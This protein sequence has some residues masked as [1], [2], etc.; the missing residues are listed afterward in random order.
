[1]AVT[2]CIVLA[3]LAGAPAVAAPLDLPPAADEPTADLVGTS[4]VDYSRKT[5]MEL[6]FRTRYVSLPSS[7]LDIWYFNE[8]DPGA[9]PLARPKARGY[10]LGIEYVLKPQPSNWIFYAEYMGNLI[11]E[12]Y[13]DDVEEPA[14]HDDGDWIQPDRFGLVITGVNYAH[15]IEAQ[16]W[17]SFLVGGGL[18]LGIVT[19]QLTQWSPGG[20]A[21][22]TEPDCLPSDAAYVRKDVCA[23]DGP[24][25]IPGVLPMVDISAGVRFNFGDS[26]NLRIEGG[27]HDLIYGG[28]AMGVVF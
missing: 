16:P 6:N 4:G 15:E 3:L 10:V 25:R 18:G 13:W 14:E 17:L 21:D 22:N 9:N 12:G 26:A 19:G 28:V 27:L 8:N 24:K 5:L 20:F 23:D 7:I 2:T 1:M 11:Q